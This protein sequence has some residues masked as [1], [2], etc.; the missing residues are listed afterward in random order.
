MNKLII[1]RHSTTRQVADVDSHQWELTPE[2][3]ERCTLLAQEIRVYGIQQIITSEETKAATTGQ[4]TASKLGIPYRTAPHLHEQKRSTAP[5][6]NHLEDFRAAIR[7]AMQT[8]DQ[9]IFGEETFRAAQKRFSQQI[10]DLLRTY[11]EETIA[12]VTHG[13]V[14]S[15]YLEHITGSSAYSFWE[16]LEMPAYAVLSLPEKKLIDFVPALPDDS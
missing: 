9:L 3:R 4:Y 8:P 10:E 15:L 12:V 1:I 11:P 7:V 5:Y 2:G 6:Y 13:T 14:M 16:Q